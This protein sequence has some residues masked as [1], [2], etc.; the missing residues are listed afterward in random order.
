MSAIMDTREDKINNDIIMENPNLGGLGMMGKMHVRVV[1]RGEDNP[2]VR[3]LPRKTVSQSNKRD[4]EFNGISL[5][6]I[7]TGHCGIV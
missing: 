4:L 3:G 6:M 7:L 5:Y 2:Q 1:N